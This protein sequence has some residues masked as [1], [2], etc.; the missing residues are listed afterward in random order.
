M[1]TS[2]RSMIKLG[3]YAAASFVTFCEGLSGRVA[4]AAVPTDAA[5]NDDG[6]WLRRDMFEPLVGDYF[7]VTNGPSRISLRLIAVED[8]PSAQHAGTVGSQDCFTLVLRGARSSKLA[9][10]AQ[11]TYRVENG[12]LGAFSLFLVPGR[13]TASGV[14]YVATFNRVAR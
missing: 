4:L 14:T 1:R 2:R 12:T 9:Q 7:V 3:L 5:M 6:G 8:V 11:D 13:A 10:L